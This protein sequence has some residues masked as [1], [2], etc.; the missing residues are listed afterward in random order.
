MTIRKVIELY[1]NLCKVQLEIPGNQE[2]PDSVVDTRRLAHRAG[3]IHDRTGRDVCPDCRTFKPHPDR[4][5]KIVLP[6]R[7]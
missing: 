7:I 1:C 3:W 5:P 4:T 2:P 6:E